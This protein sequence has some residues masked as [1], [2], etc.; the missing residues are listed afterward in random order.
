MVAAA[1]VVILVAGGV[2][3]VVSKG[4]SKANSTESAAKA[5]AALLSSVAAN[6]G[7]V[8]P[9]TN[10]T[11]STSAASSSSSSSSDGN[12]DSGDS[13]DSGSGKSLPIQSGDWRL[14]SV[15]VKTDPAFS[16]AEVTYTGSG[17]L[18]DGI[19]VF[20]VTLYSNGQAIQKLEG[21]TTLDFTGRQ[22]KIDL[23]SADPIS[24]GSYTYGFDTNYLGD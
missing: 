7:S 5:R 22:G 21:S 13:D 12:G 24:A 4:G 1:V 18:P 20:D 11:N 2:I 16:S 19:T 17:A 9:S 8:A 3:A 14:D 15:T 23:L 6:Q 10:A